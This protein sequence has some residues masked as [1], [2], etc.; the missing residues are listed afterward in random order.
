MNYVQN[1]MLDQSA[2]SDQ[3]LPKRICLQSKTV[4]QSCVKNSQCR[5]YVHF[6]KSV[7][8]WL[9]ET[10]AGRDRRE[11]FTALWEENVEKLT[12]ILS[13][14]LFDTI[15]YHDYRENRQAAVIEAK[16]TDR[17]FRLE[18]ECEAALRQIEEKQYAVRIARAGFEKVGKL[19]IA[20][21]EKQCLV[22][23]G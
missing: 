15:S 11:L 9:Y 20:F 6:K 4:R 8:A 19:G 12:A 17:E 21:F 23:K 14:L 3:R 5:G 13:D 18:E 2:Q 1:L 10:P 22:R 7:K 16:W